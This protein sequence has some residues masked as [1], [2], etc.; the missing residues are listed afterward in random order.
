MSICVAA[1]KFRILISIELVMQC[2]WSACGNPADT[3]INQYDRRNHTAFHNPSDV[4]LVSFMY[5]DLGDVRH[6]TMKYT[7]P[8]F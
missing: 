7:G 3:L 6:R 2:V 4:V 1:A 5:S 8:S